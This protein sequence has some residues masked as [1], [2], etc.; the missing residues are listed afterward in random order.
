MRSIC[1]HLI[2]VTRELIAVYLSEFAKTV[3]NAGIIPMRQRPFSTSLS[4]RSRSIVVGLLIFN[5]SSPA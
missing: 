5:P 1:V 4:C 2:D 3:K